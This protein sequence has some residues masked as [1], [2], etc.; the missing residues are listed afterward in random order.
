MQDIGVRVGV[1]GEQQYRQQ[2]AN[3]V[4]TSK[5]LAAE[6][7]ALTSG[8]D[9]TTSAQE[10]ASSKMEV[11]TRQ[12]ENQTKYIETLNSKYKAQ[13]STLN[14]LRAQLDKANQ[15][16]GEGSKESQ[17]LTTKIEQQERAMSQTR[18]SINNATAA[19]NNMESEMS[20]TRSAAESTSSA[21]DELADSIDDVGDAAEGASGGWSVFGQMVADFGTKIVGSALGIIKDL[22]KE[23]IGVSDQM[24]KFK[25]TMSFAGFSTSEIDQVSKAMKDYADLTVYSLGEVSNV[26]AQLGANGVENFEELVE[27]AGNL[28]AAAGGSADTFSTFGLV[29][30][31][32]AGAGKLTT[33][34]WKQLMNAIPGASGVL[35]DALRDAG[36]F[37]G[38]FSEAMKEGEIT[39]EEFNEAIMKVGSQP[40]AQEAATSVETF[41]GKLGRLKTQ[42]IEILQNAIELLM[43]VIDAAFTVLG[44]FLTPIVNLTRAFQGGKDEIEQYTAAAQTLTETVTNWNDEQ[45]K[46][47]RE[48]D[49]SAALMQTY[50]DRLRDLEVQMYNAKAAGED[51]S[52]IQL[53][54]SEIVKILNERVPNL[55]LEINEQTG[56]LNLNSQAILNNADAWVESQKRQMWQEAFTD[57]LTKQAQAE[58]EVETNRVKLKL[59][60]DQYN[61]STERAAELQTELD[62]LWEEFY[63]GAA[64]DPEALKEKIDAVNA[65][66]E[67]ENLNIKEAEKQMGIYTKAVDAGTKALEEISVEVDQARETFDNLM[68]SQEN[69]GTQT[70]R[71]LNDEVV[72]LYA[73]AAKDASD[74]WNRNISL[75]VYSP[76]REG[77]TTISAYKT[78]L[79]Y[80]PYD[81]FIAEL[82]KGERILTAAEA[83]EYRNLRSPE[84]VMPAVPSTPDLS[85]INNNQKTNIVMNV[86]GAQGQDE[87]A[88]A[89]IVMERIQKSV[90]SR[91]ALYA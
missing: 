38:D 40:M 8:F 78:G 47:D 9:D 46:L 66:W 65:E 10:K 79:A 85:T 7:K 21:T 84:A 61:D 23:A 36:A 41:E 63:S 50:R 12:I 88:L 13:E 6:M 62:A 32:T 60:T 39:A 4:Q 55:N 42:G 83:L 59:A 20:Q 1:Q 30:T 27:A 26:V 5:E 89:D 74:A 86:Y 49:S 48:F 54:Y 71:I 34:N 28:N 68:K 76:A 82:H 53:E 57:I 31:Q 25:N 14:T 45:L 64:D 24:I 90:D 52:A 35:Q 22:A 70:R 15:E 51:Y 3:I 87:E 16:Y 44:A 80:V 17:K 19:L 91:E 81:G 77:L 2:L 29:L 69:Y 56:L 72:P 75:K 58:A 18:T 43:P 33:E 37:V 67:R 73:R 11:L